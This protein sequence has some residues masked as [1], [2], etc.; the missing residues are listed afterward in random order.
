MVMEQILFSQNPAYRAPDE[1]AY[2]AYL[3]N[4]NARWDVL[5]RPPRPPVRFTLG[6][7]RGWSARFFYKSTQKRTGFNDLPMELLYMVRDSI[8]DSALFTHLAFSSTCTTIRKMYD[9][10][11]LWGRYCSAFG[12]GQ[13]M[14]FHPLEDD[15]WKQTALRIAN[16]LHSCPDEKHCFLWL[17]YNGLP[18]ATKYKVYGGCYAWLISL[19]KN[20]SFYETLAHDPEVL[21][22]YDIQCTAFRTVMKLDL[23][24][25]EPEA[26]TAWT[27]HIMYNPNGH[28]CFNTLT[29]NFLDHPTFCMYASNPP[30]TQMEVVIS[31][32]M[33]FFVGNDMGVTVWD[34]VMALQEA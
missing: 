4:R 1:D 30:V 32:V 13:P 21:E 31:D 5:R 8:P 11:C 7:G 23:S 33:G 16:H 24:C 22:D 28:S 20:F 18:K 14:G 12:I 2:R 27:R 9:D 15:T 17:T 34:V 19:Y 3:H 29:L 10:D 6:N 26:K 25:D